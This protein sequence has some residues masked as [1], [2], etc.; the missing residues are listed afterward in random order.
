[1]H[2]KMTE[3]IMRLL[4]ATLGAL[5]ISVSH[6]ALAQEQ[7]GG[8]PQGEREHAESQMSSPR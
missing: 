1:M 2:S 6:P 5:L 3:R 7:H 4:A 8:L